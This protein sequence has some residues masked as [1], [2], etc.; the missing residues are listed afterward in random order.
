[1]ASRSTTSLNAAVLLVYTI[2]GNEIVGTSVPDT[3]NSFLCTK[4]YGDFVLEYEFKVHPEL[5]SGVQV[6]SLSLPN[7]KEGRVHGYQ[8]E[9]DPSDR[10]WTAGIYDEA[11]RGWLNSLE[12]NTPARFAFKQQEWNHVRVQAIGDSIKTWLNGVPAADL[13]DPMTL[14]GFVAL[15]VH[16]VG[17]RQDPVW[18]RWRNL[19][20][21]ELGQSLWSPLFDGS[22]LSGWNAQEP[23]S[24]SVDDGAIKGKT[25]S[26]GSDD[27][28]LLSERAL[29]DTTTIRIEFKVLRGEGSLFL[30]PQGENREGGFE[31]KI[32]PTSDVGRVSATQHRTGGSPAA[33]KDVAAKAKEPE[34]NELV[35]SAHGGRVVTHLNGKKTADV[36]LPTS[37]VSCLL[38]LRLDGKQETSISFRAVE[39]L[40][41]DSPRPSPVHLDGQPRV[42]EHYAPIKTIQE[43]FMFTEGPAVGPDSNI[44]FTDIPNEKI[45]KYDVLSETVSVHRAETGRAN[46]L[47]F[48][49]SGALLACQGGSRQ[50]TRQDV[51]GGITVLAEQFDGKQL[52]SPN[53]LQLDGKGGIYFT[54]PRY[55]NR[56]DLEMEVEGVYYLP[57]NGELI[58]VIDDMV[59]P[60]GLVL[61]LDRSLLYVVDNG[62]KT[63]WRFQVNDDGTLSDGTLWVDMAKDCD[64]GGDGMTIDERGNIYCAG[65]G[66]VW[67]WNASG[68]LLTSIHPPQSPRQLRVWRSRWEDPVHDST[69]RIL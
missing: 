63:I 56:D 50:L 1:M 20:I 59:R 57:R 26:D 22:S 38:G 52:N 11:R 31:A 14:K 36:R 69:N 47:M 2:D 17:D 15:Q 42:V 27:A 53:D 46:G 5:N 30:R 25:S 68:Q 62:A 24:W 10:G 61:S 21:R 37:A 44:Y 41:S 32:A 55:G 66:A 19:R 48:G 67:V 12:F 51:D 43:G 7:Y 9:I 18:V 4:E 6:R 34:W 29:E 60:N 35:L 45:H 16:G 40:D 13:I 64:G 33:T 28:I 39:I 49:P 3:P 23:E 54:D 58:R 65:A 8:V